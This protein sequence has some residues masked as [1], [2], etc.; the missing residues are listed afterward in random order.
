MN[1]KCERREGKEKYVSENA[2]ELREVLTA[3][4]EFLRDITGPLKEL[5]SLVQSSIAGDKLG[6]DIAEFYKNLKDSGLPD[7]IVNELI[8]KYYDD[9]M[10]LLRLMS[11]LFEGLR[12]GRAIIAA[13]R[14]EETKSSIKEALKEVLRKKEEEE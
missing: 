3:I 4:I 1:E 11:S 5:M 8:K 13:S 2:R 7:D 14:G 12:R 10:S 6:K 9:R